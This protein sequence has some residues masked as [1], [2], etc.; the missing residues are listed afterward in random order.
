VAINVKRKKRER[1]FAELY[2][3]FEKKAL[4]SSGGEMAGG[5]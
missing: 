5:L 1:T 3:L 2:F 4:H